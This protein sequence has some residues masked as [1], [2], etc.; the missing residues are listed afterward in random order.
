MAATGSAIAARR[1]RRAAFRSILLAVVVLLFSFVS[2]AHAADWEP[3]PAEA[4]RE[5]ARPDS[6]GADAITLLD[7]SE[8][9]DLEGNF[10][11]DYFGRVK[12]FT[13]EG[14]D[15]G[16]IEI[17][18]PKGRWTLS[19]VRARS[20]RPDGRV[21]EFDPAKLVETTDFRYG[22]YNFVH[23]TIVVPGVEPGVIVEWGYRFEGA[24]GERGG[25][26][27]RFD[28]RLYTC[29][30]THT[31]YSSTWWKDEFQR[32]WRFN[33]IVPVLVDQQCTPNCDR[34]QSVT[35]TL[36]NQTGV[37]NEELAPPAIDAAPRVTVFYTNGSSTD[38]WS[39]W[40]SL[41]DQWQFEVGRKTGAL[42]DLVKQF[43]AQHADPESSL[44]D[45]YRWVQSHVRSVDELP[46]ERRPADGKRSKYRFAGSLGELMG[47]SEVS[48]FEINALM[49]AIARQ[50]GLTAAVG[51]VGDRRFQSFDSQVLGLPPGNSVT[52]VNS[53]SRKGLL[54]LEPSSRFTP[55]GSVPWYD[56]GGQCLLSG[57][58]SDLFVRVPPSQTAPGE[59]EWRVRAKLGLDGGIDGRVDAHLRD[60]EAADW[61]R[62]LW[63]EDPTRWPGA[64]KERMGAHDGLDVTF[65]TPAV[66]APADSELT[67]HA[68]AHW[69]GIAAVAGDRITVP[70][71]R[72]I[73]WRTR[74]R[75]QPSFR[76]QPLL[77]RYPRVETIRADLSLE[78]GLSVARL[79]DP[80]RFENDLGSWSVTWTQSEGGVTVER[81]LD[82]KWAEVPPQGYAAAR[83]FFQ[84]LDRADQSV[85][86]VTRTP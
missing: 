80:L 75:L 86:L 69:P 50:L 79:P 55:F 56:C 14:R 47:R 8:C 68:T 17:P 3:I 2:R 64:L 61:R 45:A 9:H 33:G 18:Y 38:Y 43:R 72:L 81:K 62:G 77:L 73:A 22:D 28:N 59:A 26:R 44:A 74:A 11:Y 57:E 4:W 66:D 48:P 71:D 85:L 54:F 51:F 39:G 46:W 25:W 27:F 82:L 78:P 84:S 19:N 31:W 53:P 34:P 29:V 24:A 35:F 32:R 67:L 52:V 70:L 16:T 7:R 23:A 65:D 40:K 37:R 30:S 12:I 42:D 1:R 63:S 76:K 58:T 60:E 5:P 83:E 49:V 10:R 36:R 6:G 41:F 20:V 13:V 15:F 21:T